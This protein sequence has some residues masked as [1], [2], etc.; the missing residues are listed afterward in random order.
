MDE[1]KDGVPFTGTVVFIDLG[2]SAAMYAARGDETTLPLI[3]RCLRLMEEQVTGCAG[4][5]VK[6]TGD[7][8]LAVFPQP[9]D[10]IQASAG[11]H[12]RLAHLD[13]G[14][15]ERPHVRMGMS[16]G[17]GLTYEGD[18][19]GD[20]VNVAA[21][22]MARARKDE[23][24]LTGEAHAALPADLQG[25]TRLIDEMTIRD[26]PRKVAVYHCVR[27]SDLLTSR[28]RARRA[29]SISLEIVWGRQV[30]ALDTRRPRLRIG[31]AADNDIRIPDASSSRHHAELVLRDDKPVLIDLS[32]NGTYVRPR[33]G[34]P[35]RVLREEVVLVGTGDLIPGSIRATPLAYRVRSRRGGLHES[36]RPNVVTVLRRTAT[37]G[38][39]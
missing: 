12:E 22:L 23:I 29:A 18:V 37:G 3:A 11:I 20:V 38:E 31:R 19:Y 15:A 9:A 1:M 36:E 35:F 6:R 30:F 13:L 32:T 39:R 5:V 2:G 16:H 8:V 26:Y 17:G 33:D 7:G 25:M 27:A 34:A 28:V 10:A 14:D 21:R 24:L 4:R